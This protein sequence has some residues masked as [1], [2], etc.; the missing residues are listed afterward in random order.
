MAL[1]NSRRNVTR[2][3]P[4][5]AWSGSVVGVQTAV[6]AASK[7]L[8]GNFVS[9]GGIDFTVLRSVGYTSISSD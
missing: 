1:G 7:V 3:R 4:N 8:L 9:T 5:R 2:P 6:P